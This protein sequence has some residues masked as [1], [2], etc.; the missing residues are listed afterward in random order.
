LFATAVF[1][2]IVFQSETTSA[3]A[4]AENHR[5]VINMHSHKFLFFAPLWSPFIVPPPD[6]WPVF[7]PVVVGMVAAVED[8][9]HIEA[10]VATLWFVSP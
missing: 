2:A 8:V 6:F 9:V 7:R 4:K 3:R 5:A 1:T 10:R